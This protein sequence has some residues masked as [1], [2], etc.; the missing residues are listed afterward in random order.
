MHDSAATLVRDGEIIAAVEEERLSRKKHASEFPR[1]SIDCVLD[2]AGISLDQVSHVGFNFRPNAIRDEILKAHAMTDF[3]RNFRLFQGYL[4]WYRTVKEGVRNGLRKYY[5][6]R[7]KILAIDH[8][9]AHAAS[10]FYCS[11]FE[12]ALVL[13]ADGTGDSF[14]AAFWLGEDKDL[15]L[16]HANR[17]P[18]SLGLLYSM[19]T[20]HLSLGFFGEG[21]TMGLAAYGEDRYRAFFD[22]LVQEVDGGENGDRNFFRLNRKY[23]NH[24]EGMLF[25]N[26]SFNDEARAVL[27]PPRSDGEPLNRR[28]QDVAASLQ[29]RLERF[30]MGQIRSRIEQYGTR[31]LCLAGGVALNS[32][33][34]GKLRST[35]ACDRLFVQPAAGDS[36][37]SL[38]CALFIA[39]R[40]ARQPR[41]STLRHCFL[42]PGFDDRA[43]EAALDRRGLKWRR[44]ENIERETARRI[45]DNRIVAWFQERMEFGPRALGHRSLLANPCDPGM[46]DHLNA[47]VKFRE[48]FRPFAASVP[49]EDCGRFFSLSEPSP[50]ML[51][52]AEVLQ[53]ERLP[54]VTHVDG[55]VR[56]QTVD[57]VV[58]PRYWKLHRET[59]RLTGVPV[60]LNT[61]FNVA[62]EPIVCS[63]DDAIACFLRTEIDA[64]VL[65]DYLIDKKDVPADAALG[66][67]PDGDRPPPARPQGHGRFYRTALDFGFYCRLFV[68][69]KLRSGE[70]TKERRFFEGTF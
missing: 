40:L 12:R 46:K 41:R 21:K 36:G 5:G 9:I 17:Y 27:G 2:L 50:F 8:H 68:E 64:L 1:K 54:S 26:K 24:P 31:D 29:A 3:P 14:T 59:E 53:P 52:V 48:P 7:G 60:L 20:Y 70:R 42:G 69:S 15:E 61:S 11:P 10:S 33:L 6:Y 16:I 55:S 13:T 62:G 67:R 58:D 49:E 44:C 4:E 65:G 37:T 19:I 43:I 22:D 38:G 39:H 23:L 35:E 51:L 30:L 56:L 34:N 57:R 47:K 63:P 25:L 32:V 28:H 45:A 18:D 66:L